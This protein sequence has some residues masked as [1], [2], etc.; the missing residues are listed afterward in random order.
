MILTRKCFLVDI[1][2][3]CRLS[4]HSHFVSVDFEPWVGETHFRKDMCFLSRGHI[5]RIMCSWVGE[6][7]SLN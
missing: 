3:T 5:T 2:F 7:L 4:N 6:H 1:S